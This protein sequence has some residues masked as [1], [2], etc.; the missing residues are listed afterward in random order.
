VDE[1]RRDRH[2]DTVE[3]QLEIT[4]P[5]SASKITADSDYTKPSVRIAGA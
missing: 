3:R 1:T 4:A 2:F 5:E